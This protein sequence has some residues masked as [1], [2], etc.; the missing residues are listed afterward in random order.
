M[1]NQVYGKF[2]IKTNGLPYWLIGYKQI[3]KI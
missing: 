1:L 2:Y 3:I